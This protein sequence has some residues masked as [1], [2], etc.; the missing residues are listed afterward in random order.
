MRRIALVVASLVACKSG[1]DRSKLDPAPALGAVAGD[2]AGSGAGSA[3][4]SAAAQSLE[5]ELAG[6]RDKLGLPAL[7]A[8]AWRDGKL[9][10]QAAVGLRKA[11]D[12]TSKVTVDDRWHLGSNTKAMTATLLAIYVDRGTLRWTDTV[13]QLLGG[14]GATLDAGYKDVTLDQLMR[15]EGGA[16]GEP[17]EPI[18]RQLWTDGAAPD[19]RIK[20]VRAIL[21]TPPAQKPGTFTYSNTGYM[22]VGAMLE[23]KTGKRWEDLMTTELFDKLAMTSCGFGAPGVK[24][25]VDQPRGHDAG[26]TPLE[27]GPSADN[28]PGLGPAGTVHCSLADYG[29]YLSMVATG[30]PALVTPETQQ[31]LQT[32]RGTGDMGYAGG[33]MAVTKGGRTLLVHS[34]SNTL[35]FVTAAVVP[36]KRFALV[37]A[38]NTASD[39]IEASIEPLMMRFKD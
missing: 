26:G 6:I 10:D 39:A 1:S 21:A 24:G 12:P 28:P 16:P 5:A 4:G 25:I 32:A 17:P 13:G 15:H 31:V 34:G 20:F 8:A 38:S 37:I 35:W 36:G 14:K 7:A 2:A 33:W 3:A 11:D 27:P 30:Q 19:A 9:L 23:A 29:K 22:I 18:W